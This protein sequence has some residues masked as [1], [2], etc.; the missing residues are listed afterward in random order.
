MR[1]CGVAVG[2][3]VIEQ[4]H[5][6]WSRSPAISV[7]GCA[8]DAVSVKGWLLEIGR[9][10]KQGRAAPREWTAELDTA[11]KRVAGPDRG[12]GHESAR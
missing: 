6:G 4:L 11:G 3:A 9:G 10:A 5:L 8:T 12:V 1:P 2:S 7:R